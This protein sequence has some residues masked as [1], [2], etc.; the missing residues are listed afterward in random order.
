[1]GV[2]RCCCKEEPPIVWKNFCR[3]W[4]SEIDQQFNNVV[5][6]SGLMP[7]G[8]NVTY[9]N[10]NLSDPEDWSFYIESEKGT[11]MALSYSVQSQAPGIET[12]ILGL[13]NQQI[14]R[15]RYSTNVDVLKTAINYKVAGW[16]TDPYP[17][18][19]YDNRP[20][21]SA[22]WLTNDTSVN[23]PNSFVPTFEFKINLLNFY[24]LI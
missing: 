1:M 14:P 22:N 16:P 13:Q 9:P 6:L 7:S 12:K 24:Y 15:Y 4:N 18:P 5:P 11:S 21:Y 10:V 3:A 8:R 19:R 20:S 2:G 17:H 23:I